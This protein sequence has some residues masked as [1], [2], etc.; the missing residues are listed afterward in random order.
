VTTHVVRASWLGAED[1]K[2]VAWPEVRPIDVLRLLA[3]WLVSLVLIVMPTPFP[4][5]FYVRG[6]RV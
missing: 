2:S 1:A 6:L 3:T 4:E 5:L